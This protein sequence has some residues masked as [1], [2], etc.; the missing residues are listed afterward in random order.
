MA[1]LGGSPLGLIGIRSLPNADGISTFNGGKTRNIN[2]NSYNNATGD[3]NGTRSVFSGSPSA[4]IAPY[5]NIGK[6]GTTDGG[7]MDI[8]GN[9][10]GIKRS[11]LHNNVVYDI[12]LLNIIEQLSGTQAELRPSD[13]AYLRNV[14]VFPNNRLMIARRF[15]SPHVSNIYGTGKATGQ[16]VAI[17]ISWKPQ[18]EDF[19]KISFGE[20]W[21]E[22]KADFKNV[23]DSL[24]EDFLGKDLGQKIGGGVAVV[25]LPGFSESLQRSVLKK[26]GILNDDDSVPL[27][28][29][30][31][32]LIKMAKRRST[33]ASEQ[34]GSGLNCTVS[35]QMVCEWEQKFISGIDPTIA[36]Q[37]ILGKILTFAT[38]RSNNYGLKKEFETTLTGWMDNPQTIVDDISKYI[39]ASL[40]DVK[41]E[42][43]A[44]ISG[45]QKEQPASKTKNDKN[46]KATEESAKAAIISQANET[47]DFLDELIKKGSAYLSRQLNK[48]RMEIE[49][50]A[51]SL[52]GAPSTPWH[53]TIG[54]PLRPIFCAGDM[55]MSQD[56]VVDLGPTLAFNDLPT[57]IKATFTLENARPWGL[58]E[59][60][61]KFNAG[62]IRVVTILKDANDLNHGETL[63]DQIYVAPKSGTQTN[64]NSLNVDSQSNVTSTVA[65]PNSTTRPVLT[66]ITPIVTAG[67]QPTP[68]PTFAN[69]FNTAL[70]NTPTP[71]TAGFG[72]AIASAQT[73]LTNT[74][75]AV[76]S[77]L[78]QIQ[79][80]AN[81]LG[82]SQI[83][84]LGTTKF[85]SDVNGTLANIGINAD[86]GSIIILKDGSTLPIPGVSKTPGL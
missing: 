4:S 77:N 57:S 6:I 17:M 35:I 47:N 10:R 43:N 60:A 2:V 46:E 14:G 61:E 42:I 11:T 1:N 34:A 9:Y 56:L 15:L 37:D 83:S 62:S 3:V 29:G 84:A 58:Q 36:W 13:F 26:L 66:P 72:N 54:N 76:T 79:T 23:L 81:L 80:Q 59:I 30:N 45:K 12:S 32:N 49:G 31:P 68:L 22:A 18:G 39:I 51:R 19:L 85:G 52:S 74:Q 41:K 75:T 67:V 71:N 65:T 25:P 8:G 70:P 5:G 33:V 78:S 82:S 24:G 20:K 38:S 73:N 86:A 69:N 7:G 40:E 50:I 55:Y 63:R 53:I 27:P 28:A 48:Y 64:P 44:F 21:E 16:P